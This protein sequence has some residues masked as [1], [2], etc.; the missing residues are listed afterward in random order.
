MTRLQIPSMARAAIVLAFVVIVLGAFVR[1][2]DAGLGCPDWPTCYG[3][4]T[5]P[6]QQVISI[7]PT[8]LPRAAG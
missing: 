6:T 4:A 7:A 2:S 5:W 8:S 1:L 3:K